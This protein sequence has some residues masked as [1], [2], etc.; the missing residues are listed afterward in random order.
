[1]VYIGIAIAYTFI[2][3]TIYTHSKGRE[4]D[5]CPPFH[6][7]LLVDTKCKSTEINIKLGEN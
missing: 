4:G 1:M 7:N 5:S 6:R 3:H 2:G